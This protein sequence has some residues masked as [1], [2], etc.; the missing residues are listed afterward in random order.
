MLAG[1]TTTL[2]ELFINVGVRWSESDLKEL[3]TSFK[4]LLA[5][6]LGSCNTDTVST[7]IAILTPG[8]GGDDT[9]YLP[10]LEALCIR[11]DVDHNGTTLY[12]PDDLYILSPKFVKMFQE[13]VDSVG[14]LKFS[15]DVP[16]EWDQDSIEKLQELNKNGAEL[17]LIDDAQPESWPV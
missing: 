5:F 4:H 16:M 12:P 15:L 13:R 17:I 6:G 2:E 3:F 14:N 7:L 11:M 1:A 8:T 10:S 9:K